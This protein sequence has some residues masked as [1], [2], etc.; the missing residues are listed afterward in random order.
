MGREAT[1]IMEPHRPLLVRIGTL[2]RADAPSGWERIEL[3]FRQVGDHAELEPIAFTRGSGRT[4]PA[5]AELA[6]V[7]AELREAMYE[8]G[9]G[10]WLQARYALH[11]SGEFDLDVST[12][13]QPWWRT[14]PDHLSAALEAE[15]KAFPRDPEHLPDWW[16]RAAGLPLGVKFRHARV[17]DTYEDGAAP[18]MGRPP[19]PENEV[20]A[21]LRYLERQPAVLVGSGLGPDIFSGGTESDVPESYHTD[22]SWIWHASVP[23]YLRKYGTPPEPDFLAHIRDQ[24][25]QPPYVDKL[26]RRTAA[27]DL[28]GRSRP[29]ADPGEALPTTG[30]IAAELETRTDPALEDPALLV[31]LAQRLAEHGIWPAAY[32]LASRADGAWCLNPTDRGWEVA[33]YAG[34]APVRPQYFERAEDAAQHLLGALLLHPARTTGGA[35]TPLETSAELADWPIQPAE[36]EP[37]LTLLRNKRLIRLPAATVVQRFGDETGNL[38]HHDETRFPATSLP[39]ER[40]REERRYRLRRSLAV[41]TGIAIPWANLPGGGVAYVLPKPLSEH[42]ADASLERIE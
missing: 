37:P 31:V 21:L 24:D 30:D 15:L 20:P 39:I 38:V 32:R 13:S 4:F 36:G 27:A 7:F 9:V 34:G 18:V 29:K 23:H 42:L 11:P 22:G 5:S 28:L 25:F 19:V 26:T 40:D 17:V 2:A 41:V 16:R 8:P 14:P 6:E 1:A 35:E 33:R 3:N 10:A 12:T